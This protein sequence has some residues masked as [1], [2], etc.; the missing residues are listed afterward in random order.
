MNKRFGL[1]KLKK[2][3]GTPN[4]RWTVSPHITLKN[5]QNLRQKKLKNKPRLLVRTDEQGRAYDSLNWR[6]MPRFDAQTKEK[7]KDTQLEIAQAEKETLHK[8]YNYSTPESRIHYITTRRYIIHPTRPREEIAYTG[9]AEI[10]KYGNKSFLGIYIS[11]NPDPTKPIH[12]S[13]LNAPKLTYEITVKQIKRTGRIGYAHIP[14]TYRIDAQTKT[15]QAHIRQLAANVL[16][17]MRKGIRKHQINPRRPR[18]EISFVTWKDAPTKL[19][20]YDL[21]EY[22]KKQEGK[23]KK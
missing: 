13:F 12:R 22:R 10:I 1:Q 4:Q 20:L 3:A 19:E 6:K 9:R 8:G 7:I 5:I 17:F 21:I 2:I 11:K 18:T 14:T 15:T 23:G 16:N